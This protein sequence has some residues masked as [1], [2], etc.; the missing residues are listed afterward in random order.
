[1]LFLSKFLPIFIYPL[2][3]FWLALLSLILFGRQKRGQKIVLWLLLGLVF[4]SS[5]RWTAYALTYQLERQY[6]PQ[7]DLPPADAIVLLGGGTEPQSAPRRT[8]EMNGA[9][10]RVYYAATLYHAGKAPFILASGGRLPWEADQDSTPADEMS[11][12][13]QAL[14]VPQDAI[15]LETGSR[16][17]EENATLSA[18][19]LHEHAVETILLVTSAM[20]MPRSAFLF[21]QAGFTVIAAPTDFTIIDA[22]W[23]TLWH[24][25]PENFM[26][27]FF[28]QAGYLGM[29]TSAL[30][31]HIGRVVAGLRAS[32]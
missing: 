15:R 28:P 30:K 10:D 19:L 29:T 4:L 7:G 18:P 27:G 24:P 31:E 11:A 1:M 12:I 16:N 32:P 3:L 13:L 17:T 26:L 6:L 5:N 2:G 21:E 22:D 8:V 14:G 20:H 25:D 23:E 9:G